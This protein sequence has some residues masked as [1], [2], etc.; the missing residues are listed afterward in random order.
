MSQIPTKKKSLPFSKLTWQ[1]KSTLFNRIIGYTSSN[2][3]FPMAMLVSGKVIFWANWPKKTSHLNDVWGF[4][5]FTT[6]WGDYS[7]VWYNLPRLMLWMVRNPK[8][9]NT[10]QGGIMK[11]WK[12]SQKNNY[13][14]QLVLADFSEPSTWKPSKWVLEERL[15]Y[16]PRDM[17]QWK[18]PISLL[19]NI[20]EIVDFFP[21]GFLYLPECFAK[22]CPWLMIFNDFVK[23]AVC[24]NHFQKIPSV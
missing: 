1:W 15:E 16:F 22:S 9:K 6:I 5:L 17:D 24:N 4:W 14:P 13:Q 21:A 20:I 2:G 23:E 7:A 8:K 10:L 19:R 3:G 11:P 18:L 12:S